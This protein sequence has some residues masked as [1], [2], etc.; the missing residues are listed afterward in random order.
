MKPLALVTNDDGVDSGFL[1][2][3]VDG[4]LPLSSRHR[5]TRDPSKAGSAER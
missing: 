5:C 4:L 2:M 1:Q 3:L